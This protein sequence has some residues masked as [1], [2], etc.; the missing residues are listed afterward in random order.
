MLAKYVTVCDETAWWS[1]MGQDNDIFKDQ[2]GHLTV[3]LRKYPEVL[4]KN[5]TQQLVSMA[6]LAA[7]DRTLYQMICGKDNISKKDVMTLFERYRT[8]LFKGNTIIYAIR[9][10]YQSCM[11]KIYCC[12]LKMDVYKNACYV[13]MI[14]SEFINHG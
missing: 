3:Q 14:L 10:H 1:Y 13:I 9:A 2:L 5:D 8:S 7:N 11:V 12:H 4:A 6:A